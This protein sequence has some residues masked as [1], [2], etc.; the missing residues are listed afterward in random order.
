MGTSAYIHTTYVNSEAMYTVHKEQ[1]SASL[2]VRLCTWT[3]ACGH[4]GVR[5][6]HMAS[7]ARVA[8]AMETTPGGEYLSWEL[9]HGK[10]EIKFPW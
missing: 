9:Q 7:H 5:H 6:A 10:V 4:I 1:R 8:M 2:F 3:W